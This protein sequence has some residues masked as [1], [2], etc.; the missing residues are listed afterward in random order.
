M[1]PD[2]I[3][4]AEHVL[5]SIPQ[6]AWEEFLDSDVGAEVGAS[7]LAARQALLGA[8]HGKPGPAPKPARALV[9]LLGDR[10]LSHPKAGSEIRRLILRHLAATKWSKLRQVYLNLDSKKAKALHG[11]AKQTGLGSDIMAKYWHR[12]SQWSLSFCEL[13]GLP[14]ILGARQGDTLPEDVTLEPTIKLPPLHDFQLQVYERLIQ[15]LERG[16]GQSAMLSLPTGAGKTRVAVEA[17]LDHLSQNGRRHRNTVLW[18]AHTNELLRQAWSCFQ[19]AWHNTSAVDGTAADGRH[20]TLTLRRAWGSVKA[21]TFALEDGPTVVF[22]SLKQLQEWTDAGTIADAIPPSRLAC[23]IFDEAHRIVTPETRKLLEALECVKVHQWTP[24]KSS[25]PTI[26]LTATPWRRKEKDDEELRKFFQSD[27]VT[28]RILTVNPIHKLQERRILSV[29]SWKPINHDSPPPMTADQRRRMLEFKEIPLDYARRLGEDP[30]RN[31]SILKCL[32]QLPD[33]R[34]VLVFGC[35]VD[36]AEMLALALRE[37]GRKAAAVSGAT[38]R[39]ERFETLR[40]FH[41][42]DLQFLCNV[43]VLTAGFDAPKVDVVCITRPTFSSI[44]YEQI[45]G[46]G[47]RGPLNGGTKKCLVLD[48]QDEIE[49]L[50]SEIMSYGRVKALWDKE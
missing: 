41:A 14:A 22:G 1:T 36:H 32:L 13:A 15:L 20:S 34:K 16:L 8:G 12:G 24:L 29:V 43:D 3:Q 23:V 28:P 44:R 11:L 40:R 27:L 33:A 35:S 2:E 17:V 31:A 45:V 46:R 9:L 26:G 37:A 18:I 39:P 30:N 4:Q 6:Q 38:P 7:L 48:V 25:P 19:Q 47:M 49:D 21:G 50:P 10:L 42:G 5:A